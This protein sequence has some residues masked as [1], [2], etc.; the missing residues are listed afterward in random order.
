[1]KCHGAVRVDARGKRMPPDCRVKKFDA[2]MDCHED[3][4]GS[5]FKRRKDGGACESCHTVDGFLPASYTPADHGTSKFPLIGGHMAVPCAKCHPADFVRARSTR[6]FMWKSGPDCE[7]CHRD[8]HGNQFARNRYPGCES[9]H[10]PNAWTALA[11]NHEETKFPLT[12]KHAKVACVDCHTPLA[13]AGTEK[14]RQY[15]GT[16]TRCVDCHPQIDNPSSG[17]K[18]L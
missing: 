15:A 17:L 1:M 8:P 7:A 12:G 5:Q 16:P 4:H 2:C 18:K 9:C 6:Q 10:N 11:F 13:K 14:I 3:A